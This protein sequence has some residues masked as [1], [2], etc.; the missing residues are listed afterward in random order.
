MLKCVDKSV[1][2]SIL[3]YFAQEL[4]KHIFIETLVQAS[5]TG[6][7]RISLKIGIWCYQYTYESTPVEN[8]NLKLYYP[9]RKKSNNLNNNDYKDHDDDDD[10]DDNAAVA[11]AAA[12]A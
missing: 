5:Q 8:L 4:Q 2:G 6:N 3:Q 10:I 7:L 12:A 11:A 9:L 1:L